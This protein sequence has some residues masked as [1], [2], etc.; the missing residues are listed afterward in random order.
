MAEDTILHID[1]LP[2]TGPALVHTAGEVRHVAQK[3]ALAKA[4]E[5][6]D[7]SADVPVTDDSAVERGGARHG[8]LVQDSSEYERVPDSE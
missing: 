8:G 1:E 4:D 3:P 2:S 6:V 5:A 7:E